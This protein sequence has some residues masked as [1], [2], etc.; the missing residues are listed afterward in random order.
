MEADKIPIKNEYARPGNM[1]MKNA[2]IELIIP[3][4]AIAGSVFSGLF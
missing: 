3:M 1:N 4:S 2:N